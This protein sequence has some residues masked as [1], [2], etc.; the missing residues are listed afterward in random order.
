MTRET[1]IGLLVGLLFIIMFGLVLSELAGTNSLSPSPPGGREDLSNISNAPIIEDVVTPSDTLAPPPLPSSTASPAGP[2]SPILVQTPLPGAAQPAGAWSPRPLVGP[3]PAK[4]S[5]APSQPLA[6]IGH[7]GD[8]PVRPVATLQAPAGPPPAGQGPPSAAPGPAVV[9][10]GRPT[11]QPAAKQQTYTVQAGDTLTK[12]ARKVYGPDHDREYKRIYQANKNVLKD[13]AR[14]SVGQ[15]LVI[16][17]LPGSSQPPAAP[18]EPKMASPLEP[19]P[20]APQVASH[21][22]DTDVRTV[23]LEELRGMVGAR[24]TPRAANTAGASRRTYTTRHGDCL[25]KIARDVLRDGTRSGVQRI[26]DANKGK[27]RNPN[28]LPIGVQLEIPS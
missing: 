19:A 22:S 26:L 24:D 7:H 23:G 12:I 3:P 2:G 8:P 10:A 16:P 9:A 25:M 18:A 20:S 15:V 11:A 27:I 5:A 1:R 13:E 28:H 4:D 21:S 14:L 6:A 17:P